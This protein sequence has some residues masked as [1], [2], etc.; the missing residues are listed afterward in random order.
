MFPTDLEFKSNFYYDR[1]NFTSFPA[2]IKHVA[3][4]FPVSPTGALLRQRTDCTIHPQVNT[5]A[6]TT[7]VPSVF[8]R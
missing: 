7:T 3:D 8:T 6:P 5:T 4:T 2:R 1:N